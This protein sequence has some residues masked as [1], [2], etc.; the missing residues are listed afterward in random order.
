MR[1]QKNHEIPAKIYGVS[2][3]I[4]RFQK[5]HEI[6]LKNH[7]ISSENH[8]ISEKIYYNLIKSIKIY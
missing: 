2:E 6:S 8:E 4:M 5:N 3:K 1:F 7:D